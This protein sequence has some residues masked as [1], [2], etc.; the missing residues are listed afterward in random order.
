MSQ[1]SYSTLLAPIIIG[2][3][4]AETRRNMARDHTSVEWTVD[5]LKAAVLKEIIIHC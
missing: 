3:L 5:D 2:K 1:E 4:P